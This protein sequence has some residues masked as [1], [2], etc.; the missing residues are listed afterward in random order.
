MGAL[1]ICREQLSED[2]RACN[3][4]Q[5]IN[6]SNLFIS[7]VRMI[8]RFLALLKSKNYEFDPSVADNSKIGRST[9][10]ELI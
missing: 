10:F 6:K 1:D 7:S 5:L 3:T 2:M 9:L 4:Q 8:K